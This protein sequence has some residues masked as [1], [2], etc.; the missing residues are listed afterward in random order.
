MIEVSIMDLCN[1]T[2]T[3]L[4]RGSSM[5]FLPQMMKLCPGEGFFFFFCSL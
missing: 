1:M 5:P 4:V 2:K 3:V